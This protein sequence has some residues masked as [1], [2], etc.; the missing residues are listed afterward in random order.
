V[1]W[2]ASA[3]S[4]AIVVSRELNELFDS[5]LM[6]S[7]QVLLPDLSERYGD[8]LAAPP[9]GAATVV[10]RTIPHDE[11]LTWR[12]YAADGRLLM[13]SHGASADPMP[14]VGFATIADARYYTERTPD[15]RWF[16]TIAEPPG[17]RR[18]AIAP[19]LWRLLAPLFLLVVA[20]LLLVPLVV[21]RGFAPVHALRAEISRRGGS[22]L[23]PLDAPR[24]PSE[25]AAIRDGVDL[26]LRRLRQA[27]EAERSFS[28]NAAHELRTPVAAALAQAQL[29]A[30]RL[31]PASAERREAEEMAA[32]LARL[33]ARLEK[34]LQ[35]ARAEAGVALRREPVDLLVPLSLLVE[36][37]AAQPGV[38]GRLRF[39]DG[40][41]DRLMV[42]ADLDALA[43]ALRNLIENA[44]RHA[45]P[46]GLVEVVAR[47][48]GTVCVINGGP[49]V[50]AERLATLRHRFVSH[51]LKGSGLGL[52]IVQAIAEQVG[53]QLILRS[54][55]SGHSDGFEATLSLAATEVTPSVPY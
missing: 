8:Q 48:N 34:L 25:L 31:P 19:T 55:A 26:L 18:H 5:V 52:S 51:G 44:L 47:A 3:I 45:P 29:L 13:R 50:P 42:A 2:I 7:V 43:I 20:T 1:L 6:E 14:P 38:G 35:L 23:A 9:P 39:D 17:H 28:A 36:E 27:L 16:L 24:M 15:G 11:Y 33:G 32:G 12:L 22:N 53:G 46:D 10:T 41:M 54:P 4:A 30:A 49:V 21:R 37:F 40:G